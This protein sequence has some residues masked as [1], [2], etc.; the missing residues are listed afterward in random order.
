[1]SVTSSQGLCKSCTIVRSFSLRCINNYGKKKCD[2]S[3]IKNISNRDI[4]VDLD[5]LQTLVIRTTVCLSKLDRLTCWFDVRVPVV[6]NTSRMLDTIVVDR[7]I[8]VISGVMLVIVTVNGVGYASCSWLLSVL[9]V[10]GICITDGRIMLVGRQGFGGILVCRS[11][12]GCIRRVGHRRAS[13]GCIVRRTNTI[14]MVMM[15]GSQG[16]S[17]DSSKLRIALGVALLLP[18][19]RLF[20]GP[21]S[22]VI[23]RTG[24]ISLLSLVVST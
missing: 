4:Q 13:Y 21:G 2:L 20:G 3:D 6:M 24:T 15:I 12:I 8:Y 18:E 1:M 19:R 22:I 14:F 9:V 23:R 16:P 7:C 11:T 5:R 17:T 10:R